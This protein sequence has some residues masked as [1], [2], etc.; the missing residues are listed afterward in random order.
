MHEGRFYQLILLL[1]DEEYQLILLLID[2]EYSQLTLFFNDS[3]F[4]KNFPLIQS[5]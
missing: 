3:K 2:E 5:K 4:Y 1:I